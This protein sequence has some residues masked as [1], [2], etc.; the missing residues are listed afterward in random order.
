MR[1]QKVDAGKRESRFWNAGSCRGTALPT[2][3]PGFGELL[4]QDGSAA[5]VA[6]VNA[7]KVLPIQGQYLGTRE[8]LFLENVWLDAGI[9]RLPL[10]LAI[11]SR[12][13]RAA[14]DARQPLFDWNRVR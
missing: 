2:Q 6:H 5:T 9:V 11:T 12:P 13:R 3:G 7:L 4:P 8:R 1:R 14:R 10:I